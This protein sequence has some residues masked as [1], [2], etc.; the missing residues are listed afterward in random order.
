MLT[1]TRISVCFTAFL[2]L[3]LLIPDSSE[4]YLDPGAGSAYIQMALAGLFAI[5]FGIKLGWSKAKSWF[6]RNRTEKPKS[7][8]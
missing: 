2:I 1:A 8:S 4:A 5:S 3:C 6:S 7:G